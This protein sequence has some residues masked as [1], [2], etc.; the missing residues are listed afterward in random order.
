[1]QTKTKETG[2]DFDLNRAA[3]YRSL[4]IAERAKAFKRNGGYLTGAQAAAV[5]ANA[6]KKFF[7]LDAA[8]GPGRYSVEPL[9]DRQKSIE[10]PTDGGAHC[11]FCK[12]SV[13]DLIAD[14]LATGPKSAAEVTAWLRNTGHMPKLWSVVD[15]ADYM[16]EWFS[17][18]QTS[19]QE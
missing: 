11:P 4:L 14:Q 3:I 7:A 8:V 15:V 13:A 10:N 18:D 2:A 5:K 17:S 9:D 19:T 6:T 12:K 16:K 1:M